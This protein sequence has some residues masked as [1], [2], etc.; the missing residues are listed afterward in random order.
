MPTPTTKGGC[1]SGLLASLLEWFTTCVVFTDKPIQYSAELAKHAEKCSSGLFS[2]FVQ[3][4]GTGVLLGAHLGEEPRGLV[5]LQRLLLERREVEDDCCALL[6]G[7]HQL[8]PLNVDARRQ[9]RLRK[10]SEEPA[11][12]EAVRAQYRR[13]SVR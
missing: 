2:A 10:D 8:I 7:D 12:S 13:G 4:L 9:H 11:G 5:R 6:A 1:Q 3:E